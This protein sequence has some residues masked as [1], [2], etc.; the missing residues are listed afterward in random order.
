MSDLPPDSEN[1]ATDGNRHDPAAWFADIRIAL[2]FLTRLPVGGDGE[3]ARAARLFPLA[4]ALVG[5][6]GGIL[7]T[8]A[9]GLGL[10]HLLAATA[11]VAGT[12]LL[13]GALH[14]D[15]LADL[16]DGFGGGFDAAAKLAAMKDSRIGAFGV[17]ALGLSL[18][19]RVGALAALDA[20]IG[21]GALVAAHTLGRA[22][23][24]MVMAREPLARETGL[25]VSAGRPRESDALVAIGLGVLFAL[26]ALGWK[27]GLVAILLAAV[28]TYG[29][30]RLARRQIGGYT[31]DVLGAI[32]QVC[33]IA[34][35]AAAAAL[36][37]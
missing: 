11:A 21:V 10:P 16:A 27:G 32:E 33:E 15:G 22:G 9:L 34:V 37:A 24:P 31:G 13:T 26:L 23:L 8:I 2:G 28:A 3:L 35:L 19:A 7:Y 25:A 36:A 6:A 12:V 30:A 18:L 20:P 17:L 1:R 14:E 29:L 4:G 5:L